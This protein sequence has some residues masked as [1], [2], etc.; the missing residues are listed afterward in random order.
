MNTKA[1]TVSILAVSIA[2][3]AVAS[4]ESVSHAHTARHAVSIERTTVNPSLDLNAVGEA[5]SPVSAD[6]P[7]FIQ[8]PEV[9]IIASVPRHAVKVPHMVDMNNCHSVDSW[10][11][12][13]GHIGY[14]N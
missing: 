2:L 9:T 12:Y 10:S 13:G 11:T 5:Y 4:V 1:F 14:C 3:G 6:M 8:V 7:A